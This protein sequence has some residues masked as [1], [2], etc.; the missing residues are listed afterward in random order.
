MD[1]AVRQG[2]ATRF[3]IDLE[4][5]ARAEGARQL[6]EL[7]VAVDRLRGRPGDDERGPGFV[8]QDVV[9]LVN[10]GEVEGPLHLLLHGKDHVVAQVVEPELAVRSVGDVRSVGH[11]PL[12]GPQGLLEEA[13]RK[14]EGLVDGTHPLPVAAGEVV[15]HRDH[16]DFP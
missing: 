3:L 15:V 9:D 11:L 5:L 2:Q 14:A 13:D 12:L 7:P 8:D 4:V 1:P 10:D 6:G 16:V